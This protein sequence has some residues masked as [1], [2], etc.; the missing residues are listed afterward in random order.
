VAMQ[1]KLATSMVGLATMPMTYEQHLAFGAALTNLARE[2]HGVDWT[3]P[4]QAPIP[5]EG[6][7][8]PNPNIQPTDRAAIAKLGSQAEQKDERMREMQETVGR[9]N[10]AADGVAAPE[11]GCG[12]PAC[13][14]R[15]AAAASTTGV[16]KLPKGKLEI[17]S[18]GPKPMLPKPTPST[19]RIKFA[20]ELEKKLNFIFSPQG[21]VAARRAA[22]A[23]EGK[24]SHRVVATLLSV[25]RTLRISPGK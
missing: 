8:D 23:A 22:A 12:T 14:G 3:K 20:P 10:P 1:T 21:P 15:A 13:G 24:C 9:A 17:F 25:C 18:A 6:V 11:E 19:D 16:G 4:N 5:V 7:F 2:K